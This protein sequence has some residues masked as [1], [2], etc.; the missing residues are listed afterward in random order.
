LEKIK[1]RRICG[2][3]LVLVSVVSVSECRAFRALL[4]GYEV[5][6]VTGLI[7]ARINSIVVDPEHRRRGI[8]RA[9]SNH[10][11]EWATLQKYK[12]TDAVP[13]TGDGIEFFSNTDWNRNTGGVTVFKLL[14]RPGR[15]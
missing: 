3:F 15:T 11:L 14:Q 13:V 8:A 5:E 2:D 12:A 4:H 1:N 6:R 7:V 10:F 9:L